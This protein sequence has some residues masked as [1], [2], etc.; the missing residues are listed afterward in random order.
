M[1]QI[2]NYLDYIIISIIFLIIIIIIIN[3]NIKLNKTKIK[4][5]KFLNSN[6]E[7]SIEKMITE[8]LKIIE[9]VENEN[10]QIKEKLDELEKKVNLSITKTSLIRYNP[11]EDTGGDL[12][13]ALALLNENNDGVILNSIFSR[14]GSYN[15]AKP[16]TKGVSE[17]HKLSQ[18]EQTALENAINN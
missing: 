16:I 10:H 4:L 1:Q 5:N 6:D 12:C 7:I 17:K 9:K 14:E 8:Y 15:Y 2:L 18:E 3:L 13:Y 11:F